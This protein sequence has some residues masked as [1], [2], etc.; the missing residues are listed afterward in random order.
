[1]FF[2]TL[3]RIDPATGA[4]VNR[5]LS[6]TVPAARPWTKTDTCQYPSANCHQEI[7][8]TLIV[9]QATGAVYS[10]RLEELRAQASII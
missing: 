10:V 5:L 9:D 3:S 2:S 8:Y 7:G 6:T 4:A 1:M